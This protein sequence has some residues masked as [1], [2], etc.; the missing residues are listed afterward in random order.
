[1]SCPVL[2]SLYQDLGWVSSW[3]PGH[4]LAESLLCACSMPEATYSMTDSPRTPPPPPPG[5]HSAIPLSLSGCS[6]FLPCSQWASASLLSTHLLL[7]SA[8]EVF[9]LCLCLHA[10]PHP[11]PPTWAL[12]LSATITPLGFLAPSLSSLGVSSPSP[13]YPRL[14][15]SPS[16]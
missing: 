14:S 9:C 5:Q 11:L 4:E 15:C 12:S 1:M 6:V 16:L 3:G 13:S 8:S 7:F 2:G 10:P